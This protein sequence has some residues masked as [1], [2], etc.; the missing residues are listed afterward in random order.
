[1]KRMN[2]QKGQA[3]VLIALAAVGLF[4]FA[5]LAID[6]SRSYSDKRHAQNTADTAALAAALAHIKE[7][8]PADKFVEAK[9]AALK[10]A[11]SNGY[12]NNGT[13]GVVKAGTNV[14]IV[15]L[16]SNPN[17]T[18]R[19][20]EGLPALANASQFIRVYIV[21]Y[22]PTTFA[23]VIGRP[24]VIN[25]AEAIARV[26][27]SQPNGLGSAM[28]AMQQNGCGICANGNVTLN[29]INSGAFSNS[30][31][32]SGDCSMDFW[33]N[34][35]YTAATGGFTMASGGA[36]CTTGN[37][38]VNGTTQT[39]PQI[40]LPPTG[41]PFEAPVPNIT[42]SGN[43]SKNDSTKEVSPGNFNTKLT[44]NSDF[45]FLPGDYCFN[46][47]VDIKGNSDVAAHNVNF[48]INGGEIG[49]NGNSTFT[50]SNVLVYGAGGNGMH[51]N[52]NGNNSCNGITFYMSSGSVTWNGNVSNTLT[53][54]TSGT[55][56]DYLIFLPY[57]NKDDFTINGNSGNTLAGLIVAP[58]SDITLSGNSGTSGFQT[59]LIGNT[60][61]LA[62]NSNTT[63]NYQGL[64]PNPGDPTIELTK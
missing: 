38:T 19:P 42:C 45:T 63:I 2:S 41:H 50:C 9:T 15:E 47:G 61:T 52:G 6:G 59:Q 51:F 44:I 55:Y 22:L 48:R 49:I 18:N 64:N 58:G 60:I 17:I 26:N 12:T 29:I 53:A 5:A 13:L 30:T 37:V 8:T 35:S 54:P 10:R 62:G 33:G 57:S 39:G 4:G 20:C 28:V 27:D 56:K 36:M 46:Q 11:A 40:P 21:S 1:M 32:P 16:C 34:G 43:G 3:L 31:S 25:A 7:P 24:T 14:V 23:R